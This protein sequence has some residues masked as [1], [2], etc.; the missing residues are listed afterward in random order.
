MA[1][2]GA[3]R[4]SFFF[5]SLVNSGRVPI[6]IDALTLRTFNC[7]CFGGHRGISLGEHL[8]FIG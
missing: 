5:T 4:R 1:T 2:F 3:G 7:D 8:H 6:D